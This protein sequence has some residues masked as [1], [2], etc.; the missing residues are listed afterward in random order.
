MKTTSW[1]RR[2]FRQLAGAGAL[3]LTACL[4]GVT[5]A[6]AQQPMRPRNPPK[7]AEASDADAAELIGQLGGRRRGRQRGE[8]G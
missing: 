7:I 2:Q 6:N 8:R 5:S 1:N 3:L 4:A